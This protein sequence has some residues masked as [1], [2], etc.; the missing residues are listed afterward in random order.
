MGPDGGGKDTVREGYDRISYAYRA[1]SFDYAASEYAV[2]LPWIEE[3]LPEGARVL[4]LGCG[5]GVPVARELSRRHQVTGVDISPVQ[6]ERAR[7]LVPAA[8]FVCADL[9]ACA[10]ENESF[11]AV[12]AF[13][14]I[15]HVPVEEQPALLE[16]VTGWLR[17][18]GRLLMTV[19]QGAWTGIDEDWFG[20]RMYWSH[21]DADTY[22][23][24]LADL[25]LRLLREGFIPEDNAGHVVLMAEKGAA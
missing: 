9:T 12:V 21:S 19:G 23:R 24:R 2:Y 7:Q 13:Y 18:G 14:S 10:F 22:R 15:I 8:E 1:D 17:P 3:R 20:A 11:D 6:I 4:D 16:R 25:G 5:C